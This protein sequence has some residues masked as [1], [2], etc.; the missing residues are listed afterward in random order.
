[1]TAKNTYLLRGK[2]NRLTKIEIKRGWA[3]RSFGKFYA[4]TNNKVFDGIE[5]GLLIPTPK[6][7]EY[8][9]DN[10]KYDAKG[11]LDLPN[12]ITFCGTKV[13]APARFIPDFN[14]GVIPVNK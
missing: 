7:F 11:D 12:Y 3:F 1:M 13:Y 14:N 5:F 6:E 10:P 4:T 9:F 2:K 8:S